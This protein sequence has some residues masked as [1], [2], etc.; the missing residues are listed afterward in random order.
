MGRSTFEGPVLSGD[1]RFG[2]L[3]NVGYTDL[4]QATDIDFSVTTVGSPA[5]AGGSSQFV[6][7]NNIPNVNGVVYTPSATVYPPVA[8]TP[9]ADTSTNIYRGV[10]M[11]IP[12][13]SQI[14]DVIVDYVT[15]MTI[16]SSALTSTDVYVSNNFVTSSPTYASASIATT[17]VGSAG[18]KTVAY[19]GTQ[20][21]NLI[22]TTT[23]ITQSNGSPNLSQ[24]VFTIA[25][26]GT[27]LSALSAG[28]F[29]FTLRYVQ[30]DNNIGTTTTYPYGNL[31]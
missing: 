14:V 30:P 17:T 13:G 3:R 16:T 9:T 1:N 25:I 27:G 24:V 26:V 18:R 6:F 28:K 12:A 19:T 11:Y 21:N 7:G 5:Y 22:A 23:D 8:N 15:A 2:P 4:V 31:D 10:V 29:N 20:L